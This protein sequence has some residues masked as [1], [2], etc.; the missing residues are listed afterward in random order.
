MSVLHVVEDIISLHLV[1][2]KEA[3]VCD[4]QLFQSNVTLLGR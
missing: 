1:L 3:R 4:S 2:T